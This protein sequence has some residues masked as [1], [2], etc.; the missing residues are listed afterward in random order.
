MGALHKNSGLLALKA[1]EELII[2]RVVDCSRFLGCAVNPSNIQHQHHIDDHLVCFNSVKFLDTLSEQLFSP[3][4][5]DLGCI[6]WNTR[7]WDWPPESYFPGVSVTSWPGLRT[8]NL[9]ISL[10]SFA[11][12]NYIELL[13]EQLQF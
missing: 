11:F 7:F 10:K 1:V 2:L 12:H 3:K 6:P 8:E 4:W 13:N 5:Q 9:R